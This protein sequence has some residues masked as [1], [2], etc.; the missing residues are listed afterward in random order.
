M[1]TKITSYKKPVLMWQFR[2]AWIALAAAYGLV[3]DCAALAQDYVT[4]TPTLSNM[5]PG[6]FNPNDV[7]GA[8]S[9]AVFTSSASGLEVSSSGYGSMYYPVPSNNEVI[10][11]K[12]DVEAVLTVTINNVADAQSNVWIG[13]PFILNDA[14]TKHAYTLGGYAGKFGY[15]D[16][17]NGGGSASWDPTGDTVTETVLLNEPETAALLAAIQAGGDTITGFNLEFDPAVYPGGTYD[18]TFD[19]LVLQPHPGLA[20]TSSQYNAA[21]SQ[22]T[23][24]WTSQASADYT[25]QYSTNLLSGFTSLASDIASGGATTTTTVTVPVGHVGYFRILQQ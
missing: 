22:F 14:T 17:N 6:A 19:S 15:A 20:I 10:L 7:Y 9:S 25:V 8:W 21:T 23:L 2:Y 12:N 1:K 3:I 18:V 16:Q 4:G 11:N 13:I 5:N 24:S